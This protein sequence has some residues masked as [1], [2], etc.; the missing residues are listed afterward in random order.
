MER[1]RR[2][3]WL[4]SAAQ[5]PADPVARAR[6][7]CEQL[8]GA[9]IAAAVA[10]HVPARGA[11]AT[12]CG[13]AGRVERVLDEAAAIARRAAD[14]GRAL[15]LSESAE[16]GIARHVRHAAVPVGSVRDGVIVLVVSDP[17]LTRRDARAIATWAAPHDAAGL[18]LRGGPCGGMAR[19]LAREFGADAVVFALFAQSGMRL[20]LHVRSGALL[21]TTRL[22]V[23][24]IWG[25]VSRHGAAFTI[26]D[27]PLHPGAELLASIGMRSAGLV[28]LENGRGI[29]I[30]ALGVASAG[31]LDVD[32]AHHLLARGPMLGP[33]LMSRLSSTVVPV[34]GA[35]GTVDLRIL[36]ARVGCRRFAMYERDGAQLRLVA[37]H[38]EDGSRL[39]AP[40]DAV[41][42]QLVCIAA[43]DGV[44]VAG[45]EAAAVRVGES[46]VLYA[47]DPEK[48]ALERL[49]LALQ[50]VRRNPF[51]GRDPDDQ[52][53]ELDAA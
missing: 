7:A 10:L 13:S 32:V 37:A 6:T 23:D 12:V 1:R 36:A 34:P 43:Q 48:R 46:S 44:G 27:L 20:D 21:R 53:R 28:G 35:D 26:G 33:D 38:A 16:R 52:E 31:E 19:G 30:G 15:E 50:D 42:Q 8:A 22:P 40:P 41:E 3:D 4:P 49:R 11:A 14:G 29:A 17:A 2:T 25:E 18:D 24:T 39:V 51:G 5:L 47:Q 9:G 45:N